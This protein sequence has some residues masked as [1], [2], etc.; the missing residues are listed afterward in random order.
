MESP[1]DQ[2]YRLKLIKNHLNEYKESSTKKYKATFFCPFCQQNRVKGKYYQPKGAIF[3]Q[4]KS[5]SWVF[6]CV[7]NKCLG[8]GYNM[9]NYMNMLNPTLAKQYQT[10]R[11]HSG[12]TGKGHD[13]SEPT[14]YPPNS[15]GRL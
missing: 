2:K 5:N 9:F 11:W 3:W 7:N 10:E 6:N 12:T 8:K 13:C 15:L 4:V 14:V 1:I